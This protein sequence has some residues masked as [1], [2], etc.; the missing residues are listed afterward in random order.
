MSQTMRATDWMGGIKAGHQATQGARLIGGTAFGYWPPAQQTSHYALEAVE[1][2]LLGIKTTVVNAGTILAA[3]KRGEDPL[4]Q[5]RLCEWFVSIWSPELSEQPLTLAGILNSEPS[6][7]T[8]EVFTKI[9]K[10]SAFLQYV[11]DSVVD[12]SAQRTCGY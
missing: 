2:N 3:R 9:Q 5:I 8:D 12:I 10:F 6:L 11:Q 7:Q 4:E 1:I